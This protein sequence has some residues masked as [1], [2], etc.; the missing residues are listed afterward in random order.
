MIELD[1][2]VDFEQ[3]RAL[4]TTV[5]NNTDRAHTVDNLVGHIR[6]V[7]SPEIKANIR[8]FRF[9]FVISVYLTVFNSLLLGLR[10][11][12][13][14][15]S[16]RGWPRSSKSWPPPRS[17]ARLRGAPFPRQAGLRMVCHMKHVFW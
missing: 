11:P 4:W 5:M 14:F 17:Q 15:R 16:C 3:P 1:P 13:P 10:L 7:K 12:R 6:G 9:R 8:G 2:T